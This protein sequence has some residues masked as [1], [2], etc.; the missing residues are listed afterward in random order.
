MRIHL[1]AVGIAVEGTNESGT[2]RWIDVADGT[3]LAQ[4]LTRLHPSEPQLMAVFIDGDQVD[5]AA[6]G[7]R[8]LAD[9]SE[10]VLLRPLEGGRGGG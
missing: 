6:E 7:G 2:D 5:P 1:R 4:L 10:L 3:T 9:G 8:V